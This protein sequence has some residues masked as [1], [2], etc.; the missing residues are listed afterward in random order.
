MKKWL[1]TSDF[2]NLYYDMIITPLYVI[3][4]VIGLLVSV[5]LFSIGEIRIGELA[6]IFSYYA[7]ISRVLWDINH[8]YRTFESRLIDAA[9]FIELVIEK[10]TIQDTE[11]AKPLKLSK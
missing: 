3:I 1:K 5:Y 10:P 8:I 11:D 2:Q 9:E 7:Y 6:L 4:N